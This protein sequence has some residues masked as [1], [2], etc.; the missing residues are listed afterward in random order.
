MLV[1]AFR[2]GGVIYSHLGYLNLTAHYNHLGNWT[3]TDA[4]ILLTEIGVVI[5]STGFLK[6]FQEIIVCGQCH[7]LQLSEYLLVLYY[8]LCHEATKTF[9]PLKEQPG[10]FLS[11]KQSKPSLKQNRGLRSIWRYFLYLDLL[12][13]LLLVTSKEVRSPSEENWPRCRKCPLVTSTA[14]F[15]TK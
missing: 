10:M 15:S 9:P 11:R 3:S 4:W 1:H 12:Y 5:R 2:C 13:S 8:L 7:W 6:T 14:S